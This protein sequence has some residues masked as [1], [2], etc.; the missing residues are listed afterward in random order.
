MLLHAPEQTEVVL[1]NEYF[2]DDF[3]EVLYGLEVEEPIF[4][5]VDLLEADLWLPGILIDELVLEPLI[6]AEEVD[7]IV[8]DSGDY[9]LVGELD[10]FV[11]ALN[12]VDDLFSRH[13]F[14]CGGV[15]LR[16]DNHQ[17][18]VVQE[19]FF[20]ESGGVLVADDLELLHRAVHV[21]AHQ[22]LLQIL[23]WDVALLHGG[24]YVVVDGIR[25]PVEV[26]EVL[27]LRIF[28]RNGGRVVLEEVEGDL[29]VEIAV[30]GKLDSVFFVSALHHH[31]AVE[32]LRNYF[33]LPL[34]LT[35]F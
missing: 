6:V 17:E 21:V 15:G 13:L 25:R 26:E 29:G 10:F 16:R 11:D 1:G 33:D 24:N 8:E 4:L 2:P 28:L 30:G 20:A 3:V 23:Y 9:L 27:L 35:H 19:A 12:F 34:V 31:G 22:E 14:E 32:Q 5:V 18:I 7:F